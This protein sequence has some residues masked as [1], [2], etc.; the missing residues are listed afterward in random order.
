MTHVYPVIHFLNNETTLVEGAIAAAGGADGVFLINHRGDD[1]ALLEPALVLKAKFP[2]L[3]IGLNL[4][5]TQLSDAIDIVIENNLDMLWVD[6]AGIS[7]EGAKPETKALVQKLTA[8]G[9]DLYAGVA[10]KYQRHESNPAQA[11]RQA[12]DLGAI[13]TTT[14]SGTGSAPATAK[15]ESMRAALAPGQKLALASGVTPENAAL[16]APYCDAFLVATGI[17][18]NDYEMNPALLDKLVRACKA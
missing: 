18:I 9:K 16:F 15:L 4:L 13:P 3:K 10:F 8:A 12:A 11:A 6:N 1:M 7:S 17:S 5:G 2:K 14:G